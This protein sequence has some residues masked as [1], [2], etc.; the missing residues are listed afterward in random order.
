MANWQ[1]QVYLGDLW[2]D[3]DL[4]FEQLRDGIVER[5]RALP[6][7]DGPQRDAEYEDIVENL[8]TTDDED[9]FDWEWHSLYD[10]ADD[11][12]RLWIDLWKVPQN[13]V[14]GRR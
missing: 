9:A 8:A 4:P 3:E 5:L 10:W 14:Q 6:Y 11:D 7:Y 2:Q 1:Q 12:H 13:E